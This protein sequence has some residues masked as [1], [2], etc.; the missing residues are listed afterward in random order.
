MADFLSSFNFGAQEVAPT[1]DDRCG[2]VD[3]L[4]SRLRHVLDTQ[5]VSETRVEHAAATLELRNSVRLALTLSDAENDA[6]QNLAHADTSSSGGLRSL[7]PAAATGDGQ[8]M[9]DVDANDALVVQTN[10]PT[11]Q[12]AV[13]KHLVGAIGVTDGSSWTLRDMKL[14][15]QGWNFKYVCKDSLHEWE[16]Q[17]EKKLAKPVIG[18]YS[19]KEQDPA[20]SG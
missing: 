3:E 13:A 6:I 19:F 1:R 18:E 14:G 9:R 16:R 4:L 12:R 11:L 20:L 8:F 10:N 2:S 17:N 7:T 5:I 15:D